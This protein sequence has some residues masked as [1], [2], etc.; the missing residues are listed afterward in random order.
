MMSRTLAHI[1]KSP[2]G[3]FNIIFALTNLILVASNLLLDI[4]E[5]NNASVI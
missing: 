3:E 4:L 5:F 1:Q 2:F